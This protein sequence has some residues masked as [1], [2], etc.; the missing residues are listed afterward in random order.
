MFSF[1]C[2]DGIAGP[3]PQG[4]AQ[5]WEFCLWE[6]RG[7]CSQLGLS[8]Q[9]VTIGERYTRF[10]LVCSFTHLPVS[11][12][13][14]TE[15][16]KLNKLEKN[17]IIPSGATEMA[18]SARGSPFRCKLEIPARRRWRQGQPCRGAA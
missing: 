13:N 15:R 17:I 6:T 9:S 5:L 18:G 2:E 3:P 4:R 8:V 7:I 11:V 14:F 1:V 12:V 10:D 16:K